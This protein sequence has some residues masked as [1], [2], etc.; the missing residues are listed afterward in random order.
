MLTDHSKGLLEGA[1]ATVGV[2][3]DFTKGVEAIR[4]VLQQG[5]GNQRLNVQPLP[6]S[7]SGVCAP[8][9]DGFYVFRGEPKGANMWLFHAVSC[10][11]EGGV[12][13]WA[14]RMSGAYE[15]YRV[16]VVEVASG[17][18]KPGPKVKSSM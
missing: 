11:V 16:T 6:S 2:A 15:G 13:Q 12:E 18:R 7:R 9:G 4:V 5:G 10:V 3:Q 14:S 8:S 1:R 17:K